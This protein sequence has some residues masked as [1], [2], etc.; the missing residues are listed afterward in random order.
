MIQVV[1][2]RSIQGILSGIGIGTIF[3][4]Y[5]IVKHLIS[6]NIELNLKLK[7]L[8]KNYLLTKH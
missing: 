3:F 6:E 5:P 2:A 7:N 8:E 1:I 4:C